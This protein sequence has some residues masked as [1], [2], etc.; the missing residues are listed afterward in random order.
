MSIKDTFTQVF[1]SMGRIK[2]HRIKVTKK[3]LDY[4]LHTFKRQRKKRNMPTSHRIYKGRYN[5]E[6]EKRIQEHIKR[7]EAAKKAGLW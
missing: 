1:T 2:M 3:T 5:I 6:Q 7:A 4:G